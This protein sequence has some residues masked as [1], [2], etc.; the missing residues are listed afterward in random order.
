MAAGRAAPD[1]RAPL[2]LRAP[3]AVCDGHR[4]GKPGI[5]ESGT[6]GRARRGHGA[7]LARLCASCG[8]RREPARPNRAASRQSRRR[9]PAAG[10]LRLRHGCRRPL[11]A[12]PARGESPRRQ[13]P[14]LAPDT[15]ATTCAF[16]GRCPQ[17]LACPRASA[18]RRHRR[19][20]RLQQAPAETFPRERPRLPP[21]WRRPRA[22]RPD[23]GRPPC[24][25]RARRTTAPTSGASRP[26]IT[27]MPSSSTQVCSTRL[28]CRRRSSAASAVRSTR[29]QARATRTFSRAAPGASPMRQLSQWA[30]EAKPL[31]PSRWSNCRMRTS[32]S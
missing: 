16:A 24:R 4:S 10:R 19:D 17:G 20:A 25:D 8:R 30:H 22:P 28:A 27:T 29:L 12:P 15:R 11:P 13:P 2:F 7:G 26:R 9:R 1:C 32:S 3:S 18:G 23:T 14:G 21:V 31:Q 6:A 5:Q